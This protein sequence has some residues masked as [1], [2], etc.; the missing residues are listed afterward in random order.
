M[1]GIILSGTVLPRVLSISA[2]MIVAGAA[3]LAT[4]PAALAVSPPP[5][6]GPAAL[7]TPALKQAL[8]ATN[9]KPAWQKAVDWAMSKRGTP[10]V[11]GGTG[12]GGFDC[13]GLMLRAYRA[14]GIKLP[15]VTYDQYDAFPKKIAWKDLR[16]GDL[17]FFSGLGHVGMITKPGYMVHAPQTG[18]VVK[19]EKLD[20]WRR[21]SFAG[22]VRPD[23]QGVQLTERVK[24]ATETVTGG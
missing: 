10:Y 16:A 23:P 7:N 3:V 15:R 24:L 9:V 14:A 13:S 18:D 12:H 19:E 20:S 22:A 5:G 8:K 21:D 4:S 1:E 11:W 6:P 17:V 2:S